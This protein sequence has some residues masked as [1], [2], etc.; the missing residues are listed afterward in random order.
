LLVSVSTPGKPASVWPERL[1]VELTLPPP[2]HEVVVKRTTVAAK[3]MV[4]DREKCIMRHL[5]MS[6]ESMD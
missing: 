1:A 4:S 6:R 5:R 3:A 2:P